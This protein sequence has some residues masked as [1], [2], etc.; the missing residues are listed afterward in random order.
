MTIDEAKEY[1][2]RR[3]EGKRGAIVLSQNGRS[4]IVCAIGNLL[5]RYSG[6]PIPIIH[7]K[8]CGVVPV[9]EKICR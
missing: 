9:L 8:K 7:C 2:A 4:T 5:Q 1:V 3:L 6:C